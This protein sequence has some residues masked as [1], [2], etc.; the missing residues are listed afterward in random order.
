MLDGLVHREIILN[1]IGVT[2]G[3]EVFR[4]YTEEDDYDTELLVPYPYDEVYRWYL[5]MKIDEANGE[6]VKANIATAKYNTLYE[7]YM[8]YVNRTRM[9]LSFGHRFFF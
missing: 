8:D 7:T 5:E 3:T 1:H 4:G 6:T 2:P 9:P